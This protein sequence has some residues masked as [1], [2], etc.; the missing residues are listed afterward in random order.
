MGD[1]GYGYTAQI[2]ITNTGEKSI[3]GWYL[4]F[5]FDKPIDSIWNAVVDSHV[6]NSYNIR[7]SGYN[8]NINVGESVTFGFSGTEGNITNAP[9]NYDLSEIVNEDVDENV[10]I[11]IDEDS[12]ELTENINGIYITNQAISSLSGKLLN[13][14]KVND[15][16]YEVLDRHHNILETEKLNI[17][18]KWNIDTFQTSTKGTIIDIIAV[19]D[20]GIMV[21]KTIAYL[22]DYDMM[23]NDGD[24]LENCFEDYFGTDIDLVDTDGDGLSDYIE[25][26][27][28]DTDPLKIDT[29]GNG[30]SDYDED[31]DC[32]GISNG[33]ELEI[34]SNPL[35]NDSD[36]DYLTDDLEL[37][38]GTSPILKDTDNNGL[39]DYEEYRLSQMNAVFDKT[40]GKYTAIFSAD[41]M[42][43][44]Y[45]K[46]VIPTIELTSDA[47]GLLSFEM[48]MV[49]NSYM[50]NPSMSGYLGA[51][52]NFTTDGNIDKAILTFTYNENCIDSD[53]IY[54]D[55]FC[56]TIYYYNPID[57]TFSS[58]EGQVWENNKVTVTLSHFSTYI[59]VNQ[60][61]LNELWS[62]VI[63]TDENTNTTNKND[64]VFVIDKSGSMSQNDPN[65]IRTS[66]I[67]SFFDKIGNNDKIALVGFSNSAFNYSNGLIN[68]KETLET[69]I[70]TFE[71]QADY[72]GTY[73][74][75]GIDMAATILRND[76]S[77][78]ST[79]KSIFVLT[80][81]ETHDTISDS[82][83]SSL[84]DDGITVYTVGLGSV[85]ETYLR[86]IANSTGGQYFY[87]R[88][89]TDLSKVFIDFEKE[90]N[91]SDKNNDG[92][93]DELTK[94]ICNGEITTITGTT[95]FAPE[96]YDDIMKSDDYD[97]DNLKNGEEVEIY[98]LSGKPYIRIKTSPELPDSDC[99]D[100]SDY[101]EV[102]EYFTD[103]LTYNYIVNNDDYMYIGWYENFES[104]K[105]HTKYLNNNTAVNCLKSFVDVVVC[106][107]EI[108]VN[109]K[110]RVELLDY[111][112]ENAKE[113]EI[114]MS[115]ITRLNVGK[116]LAS[117]FCDLAQGYEEKVTKAQALK[118]IREYQN[119]RKLLWGTKNASVSRKVIDSKLASANEELAKQVVTI[120]KN[121]SSYSKNVNNFAN[122][123]AVSATAFKC[124][125][126]FETYYAGVELF[127]NYNSI[128]N[129]LQYCGDENIESAIT[130]LKNDMEVLDKNYLAKITNKTNVENTVVTCFSSFSSAYVSNAIV[131]FG[132]PGIIVDI[133]WMASSYAFDGKFAADLDNSINADIAIGVNLALNNC[134]GGASYIKCNNNNNI[135]ISVVGNSRSSRAKQLLLASISANKW[136]EKKYL[137]SPLCKTE[138]GKNGATGNIDKLQSM[139]DFYSLNNRNW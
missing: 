76:H 88:T 71:N 53:K 107:G 92:L 91:S 56:P 79:N 126:D 113:N 26:N 68:D 20:D 85:S 97:E 110:V 105:E 43:I 86:K 62:R 120:H 104:G 29:N 102:K 131:G 30:I 72:G 136:A 31:A 75:K 111:F 16:Y 61:D 73:M 81:G 93:D 121:G 32:D 45:D 4:D 66:L 127:Q 24:G 63:S 130:T 58:V 49:E 12:F 101:E 106:G 115:I 95:V 77:D 13:R 54:S 108:S 9:T 90:F 10:Q 119:T 87:A 22:D 25:L 46:A 38:F 35:D 117:S 21:N 124:Y 65:Y 129:E 67:R 89:S 98:Y 17:S 135:K 55:G 82:Y 39:T 11:V 116:D 18:K 57:N 100:Y 99:D 36:N 48:S 7:N 27:D 139:Y 118:A 5:D 1:W 84:N 34:G 33:K 78:K 74:N 41:Q 42:G 133:A 69:A 44:S 52:Y 96:L 50:L 138:E 2:T 59:L 51:A 6:N 37:T 15:F 19:T 134:F 94:L 128:I 103:P 112:L 137:L 109:K 83:L 47:K 64:I 60:Q 114:N 123:L 23:D 80:D 3:E 28:F 14:N 132:I 40:T 70:S 8:A 122:I 125:T